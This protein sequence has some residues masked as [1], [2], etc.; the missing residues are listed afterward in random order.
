MLMMMMMMIAMVM[1]M[2]VTMRKI[3]MGL[4]LGRAMKLLMKPLMVRK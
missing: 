4:C 1:E 3:R 2:K